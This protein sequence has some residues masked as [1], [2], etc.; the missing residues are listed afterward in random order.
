MIAEPWFCYCKKS[1]GRDLHC[2]LHCASNSSGSLMQKMAV[3]E[4]CCDC[5]LSARV[6]ST[7]SN[8]QVVEQVVIWVGRAMQEAEALVCARILPPFISLPSPLLF[9][10]LYIMTGADP[11]RPMEAV[12]AC[13]PRGL[14]LRGN[15]EGGEWVT[16]LGVSLFHCCI[17]KRR[18]PM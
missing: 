2:E 16:A 17:H 5:W 3:L 10:D 15:G 11:R 18:T 12:E 14:V 6:Q 9:L 4:A 1:C 8:G 13:C 7:Q